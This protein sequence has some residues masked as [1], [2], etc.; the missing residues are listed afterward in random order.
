MEFAAELVPSEL[1]FCRCTIRCGVA[2]KVRGANPG[3]SIGE[4]I[5]YAKSRCGDN[6]LYG[7][8]EGMY[9]LS[10]MVAYV[11]GEAMDQSVKE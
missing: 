7:L 4:P 5:L 3:S 8:A 1:F 6:T 11:G 10:P 2:N 9:E